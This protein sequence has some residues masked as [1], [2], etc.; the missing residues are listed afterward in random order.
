MTISQFIQVN[1]LKDPEK[2]TSVQ[3]L[4]ILDDIQTVIIDNHRFANCELMG[5]VL[6]KMLKIYKRKGDYNVF[7]VYPI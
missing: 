2:R 3:R 4:V 6:E 7:N 5:I 1:S